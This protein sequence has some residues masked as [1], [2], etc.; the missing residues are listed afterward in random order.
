MVAY[1]GIYL[2]L[3]GLGTLVYNDL[4]VRYYRV[5]DD[6][7]P[8]FIAEIKATYAELRSIADN[9]ASYVTRIRP[10]VPEIE[11]LEDSDN[12]GVCVEVEGRSVLWSTG[13]GLGKLQGNTML[14]CYMFIESLSSLRT[15]M[16]IL[17]N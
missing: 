2:S 7:F 8:D 3:T 11:D 15:F 16:S 12:G 13:I 4:G 14:L 9:A 1:D 6:E 10:Q 17:P 5:A